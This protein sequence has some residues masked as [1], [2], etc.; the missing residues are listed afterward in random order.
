MG[1]WDTL[2]DLGE[3][4][5]PA[6]A[7]AYSSYS[8]GQSAKDAANAQVA[9]GNA[10]IAEQRRQFD[11]IMQ[12][13]APQ[14]ALGNN[15]VNT[16]SRLYGYGGA[17]NAA[18]APSGT[19]APQD[20]VNPL[21]PY[22]VVPGSSRAAGLQM[23]GSAATSGGPL[24][25]LMAGLEGVLSNNTS[26]AD[27]KRFATDIA[28]LLRTRGVIGDKP[29]GVA[30]GVEGG[31]PAT[32]PV[33]APASAG[34]GSPDMS[35]FFTSPD[36]EFRRSEGNR[37]IGNSFAARG[38][39]LSGN[40]LRGI[41]DFNSNLASGEFNNFIQRQL[42]MAGLGGAATSQGVD[43]AQYTGANV[44]NVLGQQGNA[45]ASGIVNQSNALT[46]GLNDLAT[47]LG[48][49]SKNKNSNGG[50][51][52]GGNYPWAMSGGWNA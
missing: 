37:D 22:G 41:T 2:L 19:S 48:N 13:L 11:L 31:A 52:G 30:S 16:L 8:Q 18:V 4:Y 7:S 47:W 1:W 50:F 39:A 42:Q 45:R 3:K 20:G 15:A 35:V 25:V 32:N 36:Y 44:S 26:R 14:R 49:W 28:E 34:T 38:G 43:A 23:L 6:L 51:A 10:A 24:G 27:H 12:M 9:G 5:G 17:P 46:G 33:A 21:A 40:A 29:P